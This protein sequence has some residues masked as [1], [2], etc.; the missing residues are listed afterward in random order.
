VRALALTG[1]GREAAAIVARA[2]LGEHA[3]RIVV[4]NE[5]VAHAT[6][7]IRCDPAGGSSLSVVEIGGQDAKF[8]QIRDG[9]IVESDMNKACSAGTG[10]FLE[11]QAVF[12]G[13]QKIEDFTAE[14]S[15]ASRPPE[16][17][18]MCTVFVADA[19]AE[20]H[21]QGFARAD[22]FG[23]FQYAVVHNYLNRVM[24]QRTFADRIF[25]QG[26]PATGPSLAWTLAGVTG[27]QVLVPANPGAMGAWGIGLCAREDLA[28][29]GSAPPLDLDTI[30]QAEVVGRAEFQCRD[31]RCATLCRISRTEVSVAGAQHKVLSG[32]ACPRYEIAAR[33]G[34]E[35]PPE[36]PSAFDERQALLRAWIVDDEGAGDVGIPSVGAVAGYLPWLVTFVRELGLG[37]RVLRSDSRS[38]ARGEAACYAFDACAPIKL[39][40]GVADREVACIFLPKLLS[41]GDRD[42]EGGQTCPME[43]ALP[44]MVREALGRQVISPALDLAGGPAATPRMLVALAD[45]ARALGASRALVP[46]AVQRAWA[47]QR[48]WESALADIGDRALGWART[49]G[50]PVVVVC[51]SLHTIC[52]RALDAGIPR[53]L[54]RDGVLALPM[55]CLRLPATTPALER[56]PWAEARRALRAALAC[57]ARGD[58]YPLLL[59]S[60]GCGPASF[61]EQVF[62]ALM[63]GHPHTA[64]ES[65]GHGGEAGFV[66]R[67]QAF[68]H[69][70]RRHDRRPSPAPAAALRT[71]APLPEPPIGDARVAVLAMGDVLSSNIAAVYRSYG[72]DAVST[73]PASAAALATGRRDCSGKEC[74]PYQLIWGSFRE[75]LER[76][77]QQQETVLLQ[78]PGSG[79]CRNCM[80]SVKDQLTLQRMGLDGQVRS[81]HVGMEKALSPVFMGRLWVGVVV[82]DLLTQLVAWHRPVVRSAVEAVYTRQTAALESLLQRPMSL[83]RTIAAAVRLLDRAAAEVAA[84][85]AAAPARDDLRAVLVSGDVYL[86]VDEFAS[87]GLIK[88]LN[89]RGL[90][91]LV[92]PIGLLSEYLVE[93]RLPDLMG[94]PVGRVENA[95]TK[96]LMRPVRRMLSSRV[97]RHHPWLPRDEVG[98]MLTQAQRLLSRYPKGEAPMTIASVLHHWDEELCD[99]VV[100]VSPWGCGPAL[101]A[102]SL[103]RHEE[104]IPM[105]FIYGDGSPLDTRRLDGFGLRL[106]RQPARC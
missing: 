14:A 60:F 18:Q 90:R 106:H 103:L 91:V 52:D 19:A 4:C 29:L 85:A 35:L 61:S 36:A 93:E 46:R 67:V 98:S 25:F 22:L 49:R 8:I 104:Q 102:E 100:V 97:R 32:G 39:A 62:A 75:H 40:H 42:D 71:L 76:Q 73:G 48:E 17:G 23:G 105:L 89:E 64:L 45:A 81:R 43:Q 37:V 68:L 30:A 7:A 87:D 56:V 84:L 16:L 99:G 3:D 47:A 24:G 83:S 96:Q 79:M 33:A 69:T 74:L 54:R 95:L 77:D 13:V 1:S 12:Y 55:D 38:L 44:D 86:R 2:A 10:S 5:I 78:V 31:K 92:E 65:D 21:N 88:R 15:R 28:E 80:F 41:L 82:G 34:V 53:A 59:S 27:R 6:A 57:R 20:A 101:V 51:G 70:V 66:T 26:K 72:V 58:A 50:L 9:R 63:V 94:L 11:E